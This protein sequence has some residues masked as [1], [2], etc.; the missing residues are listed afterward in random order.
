MK[1]REFF[2][3]PDLVA[4]IPRINMNYHP[5]IHV[6]PRLFARGSYDKLMADRDRLNDLDAENAAQARA[7]AARKAAESVISTQQNPDTMTEGISIVGTREATPTT[8]NSS[9]KVMTVSAGATSGGD[10]VAVPP[11]MARDPSASPTVESL[12]NEFFDTMA[13]NM[14]ETR[15]KDNR[16]QGVVVFRITEAH[17]WVRTFVVNIN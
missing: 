16:T 2:D 14:R 12:L 7:N 10:N 17:Q 8:S 5:D 9:G 15:E 3:D 11:S 6:A 4:T 1:V 13:A